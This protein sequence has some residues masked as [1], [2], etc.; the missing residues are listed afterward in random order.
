MAMGLLTI[1]GIALTACS[2]TI[3]K[4]VEKAQ[5]ITFA[6]ESDSKPAK[7]QTLLLSL[8]FHEKTTLAEGLYG[9]HH[10]EG[11]MRTIFQEDGGFDLCGA[12]LNSRIVK[13]KAPLAAD[14]PQGMV[15]DHKVNQSKTTLAWRGYRGSWSKEGAWMRGSIDKVSSK[16]T[17][18]GAYKPVDGGL[19]WCRGLT[20]SPFVDVT[21]CGFEKEPIRSKWQRQL[22][23]ASL[24]EKIDLP[25]GAKDKSLHWI[26]IGSRIGFHWGT[27]V[28]GS[29]HQ[30]Q[31]ETRPVEF[32][33]NHLKKKAK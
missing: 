12:I 5:E 27:A 6:P 19:F 21:L 8:D 7:G 15:R 3:E 16:G 32:D 22:S 2:E 9:E 17:C 31:F 10:Q 26:M 28:D 18:D 30:D 25:P 20:S 13:G 1:L 4:V 14:L 29:E 33:L 23:L 11:Q 24:G